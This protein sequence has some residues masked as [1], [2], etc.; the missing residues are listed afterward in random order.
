MQF[1]TKGFGEI[2]WNGIKSV[3]IHSAWIGILTIA[4]YWLGILKD[5]NFG[6]YAPIVMWLIGTISAF[7]KKLCEKYQVPVP[8]NY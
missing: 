6:A 7:L 3:L 2:D 4:L 1:I 5:F 8:S